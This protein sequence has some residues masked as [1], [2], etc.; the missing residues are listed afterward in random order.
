[1]AGAGG[2]EDAQGS[3]LPD[4]GNSVGVLSED[5]LLLW[6]EDHAIAFF[7]PHDSNNESVRDRSERAW[8]TAFYLL[9][10]DVNGD[11][12]PQGISSH[13]HID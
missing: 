1:M 4:G 8:F 7:G 10:N 13:A 11:F 5:T 2:R 3:V 6:L 9:C 12:R